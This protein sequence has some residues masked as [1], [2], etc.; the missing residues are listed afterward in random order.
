MLNRSCQVVS[1]PISGPATSSEASVGATVVV[2]GAT[3]VVV[4]ATVV[5]VGANVELVVEGE[6]VVGRRLGGGFLLRAACREKDNGRQA[7][8]TDS[9]EPGQK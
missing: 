4:G 7:R 8:Q 1:A 3:V 6:V 5:V 9:W 2:V